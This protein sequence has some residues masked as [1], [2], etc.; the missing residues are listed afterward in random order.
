MGGGIKT[1]TIGHRGMRFRLSE[2]MPMVPL[3]D[4][5]AYGRGVLGERSRVFQ[6]EPE[7]RGSM[8]TEEH[9]DTVEVDSGGRRE[10]SSELIP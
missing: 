3:L 10:Q 1:G 5:R 9:V 8:L 2:Q 4:A 6:M 7:R